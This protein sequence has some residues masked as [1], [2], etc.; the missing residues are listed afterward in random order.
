MEARFIGAEIEAKFPHD[1]IKAIRGF[2]APEVHRKVRTSKPDSLGTESERIASSEENMTMGSMALYI[3]EIAKEIENELDSRLLIDF[4]GNLRICGIQRN[5][6]VH[7]AINDFCEPV[8]N[9]NGEREFAWQK[10]IVSFIRMRLLYPHA[11]LILSEKWK[12]PGRR[13]TNC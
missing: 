3:E 1:T 11:I 6:V 8:K 13:R 4:A 12:Q 2:I 7:G 5:R 10:P 9:E